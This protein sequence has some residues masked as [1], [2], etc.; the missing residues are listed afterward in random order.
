MVR[1]LSCHLCSL[2][3]FLGQGMTARVIVSFTRSVVFLGNSGFLRVSSTT[4]DN[5]TPIFTRKNKSDQC[6]MHQSFV[7]TATPP[8]G[9][10]G[11]YDFLFSVPCYEPHP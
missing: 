9:N 6:V 11:D 8:T 10:G 1:I 2:G 5:R 7:T 3:S 4:Y